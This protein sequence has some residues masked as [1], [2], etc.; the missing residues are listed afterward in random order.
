MKLARFMM[1][2]RIVKMDVLV[3]VLVDVLEVAK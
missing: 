2:Y 1:Q 3:H